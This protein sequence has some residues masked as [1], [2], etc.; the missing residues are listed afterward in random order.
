M[1][2]Y[3]DWHVGMR[4]VCINDNWGSY[5]S[6]S[7]SI[8]TRVPMLNEVLTIRLMRWSE[9]HDGLYLSFEEIPYRQADGPVWAN[10]AFAADFFR[11]LEVRKT[12][13][14]IFTA[15]LTGKPVEEVV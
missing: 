3:R 12:D 1:T 15:M 4:V 14:S 11:P 5:S 10:I 13:I 9:R 6:G 7:Y 8:P 2:S